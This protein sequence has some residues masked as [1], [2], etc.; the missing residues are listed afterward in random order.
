MQLPLARQRQ[1]LDSLID[2]GLRCQQQ[3]DYQAAAIWYERAL[4]LEPTNF[5]AL[6]LLGLVRLQTGNLDGGIVLLQQS[7]AVEPRQIATLNNLAGALRSAGRPDAAIATYRRALEVDSS[8]ALVLMNLGSA[9]L[10]WGEAREA[11]GCFARA[12]ERDEKNPE[13]Y[14]WIGHLYRR[15]GRPAEAAEQFRH[16]LRLSPKLVKALEGLGIALDEAGDAVG[17]LEALRAAE[18]LAPTLALRVYRAYAALRLADWRDWQGDAAAVQ[19]TVVPPDGAGDPL[20]IMSLPA[21]PELLRSA[22]ERFVAINMSS[23]VRARASGAVSMGTRS[24][25]RIRVAYLSPDFRNHAVGNIIAEVFELHDADRFEVFA[26]AWGPTDESPSRARIMAAS[27]QFQDVS[28]ASDRAVA[29]KLCADGIDIAVDLAGYTGH[30]RSLI[31]AARPAP[32]QVG[33]LGFPGTTGASY[34]DYFVADGFTV[35]PGAERHFTERVVRLPDTYLPY[36]R[37]RPVAEQRRRTDYELPPDA[38][39]LACFGQIRK[40]NPLVFDVW[41]QILRAAPQAVLWLASD[42]PRVVSKLHREAEARGVSRERLVFASPAPDPA[43]YLARYR[44]IDLALDTFPY[45]SHSTAAD[46]LWAG[47]P[48]IAVA[49]ETFASRVSGSVLRAAGFPEL[50]ASSLEEY[51]KLILAF[52]ENPAGLA[53]IRARVESA[54]VGCALFDTPRFVAALEQ[55]YLQMWSRHQR[56]EPPADFCIAATNQL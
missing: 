3:G 39:V 30:S 35:P 40:I 22:A 15:L 25:E 53:A 19:T 48:L 26:Y 13:I 36:D 12:L 20:R 16:A 9:L 18:A 23:A 56:A 45:G 38:L 11:A 34:M 44:T 5:D 29:E 4:A 50:V 28:E 21:T 37:T 27:E 43:E 46:A 42:D 33:W 49:G 7:L 52:V 14:Y 31:F 10:E 1:Q 55:A 54:Q 47:C 32:I 6:Q 41:M 17:A 2:A 8:H 51:R 24:K